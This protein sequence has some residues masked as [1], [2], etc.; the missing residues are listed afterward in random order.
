MIIAIPF[1]KLTAKIPNKMKIT[2][3][4]TANCR[5]FGMA[6]IMQFID[7]FNPSFFEINLRGLRTLRVLKTLNFDKL[8]APSKTWS[9]NDSVTMKQSKI[10]NKSILY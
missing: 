5:E 1:K 2:T 4:I 10:T 9:I 7:S 8:E 6:L 3:K